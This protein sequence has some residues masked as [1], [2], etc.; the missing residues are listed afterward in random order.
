MN[1]IETIINTENEQE[2]RGFVGFWVV[3]QPPTAT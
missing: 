1:K 3:N 2:K